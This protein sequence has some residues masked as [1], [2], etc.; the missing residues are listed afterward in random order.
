MPSSMVED[1]WKKLLCN[2]YCVSRLSATGPSFNIYT[3]QLRDWK[4]EKT[5]IVLNSIS[6][7]LPSHSHI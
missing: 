2:W 5:K 3:L 7:F 4:K 6:L 1:Q